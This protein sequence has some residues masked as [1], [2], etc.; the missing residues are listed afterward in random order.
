M[1]KVMNKKRIISLLS[2]AILTVGGSGAYAFSDMPDGAM[3]TAMQNAVDAG[4]IDGIDDTT[5]APYSN[6]TRSQ[7]A[8][9]ICRAFGATTK[10]DTQFTDIEPGM[11]YEDY[12]SYAAAMGAFEGDEQNRFNPEKNITFEET[13]LVLSRVFGFEPYLVSGRGFMLGDCDIS[14]LDSFGD[15]AEISDWAVDGA[16][17]IVGNGGWTGIDGKLKPKEYIT[18]GEFAMLMDAIVDCYIDEPGEYTSLPDGTIMVRSGGVVIDGLKTDSNVI[19]TYAVDE[20]GVEIKN[21][22]I[23]GVTLIL[24]G[25]DKTP[26]EKV[27]AD[28]KKKLMPDE[29]H[30]KLSGD[31][32]DVRVNAKYIYTKAG[33]ANIEYYKG[34][35]NTLIALNA[36][37]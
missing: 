25:A 29:S 36:S 14:V 32:Y 10:S 33:E 28:G 9:I 11:W 4:L 22:T 37:M 19:V 8:A 20:N 17:Y 30:V 35:D 5:I 6:I 26:V 15:K 3:G 7:M 13:Y 1:N 24:G 31:F 18:R 21:S 27:L 34:I 12:V 16:K 2:A 23:N